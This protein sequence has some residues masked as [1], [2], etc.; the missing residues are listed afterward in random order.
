MCNELVKACR[1]VIEVF[2]EFRSR[3]SPPNNYFCR[4]YRKNDEASQ[5]LKHDSDI[6]YNA[7]QKYS[8]PKKN[9]LNNSSNSA[10][11]DQKQPKKEQYKQTSSVPSALEMDDRLLQACLSTGIHEQLDNPGDHFLTL[12]T[13]PNPPNQP[14]QSNVIDDSLSST[15]NLIKD[16]FSQNKSDTFHQPCHQESVPSPSSSSSIINSR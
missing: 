7:V 16:C 1:A 5:R 11:V 2:S 13:V 8:S 12:K 10:V 3:K 9:L 15:N 14:K 4:P 6:L